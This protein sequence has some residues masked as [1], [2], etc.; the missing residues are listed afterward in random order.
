MR[1]TLS[2]TLSHLCPTTDP[3]FPPQHEAAALRLLLSARYFN[4]SQL[5]GQASLRLPHLAPTD[6]LSALVTA[7]HA[8]LEPIKGTF[9]ITFAAPIGRAQAAPLFEGWC[10][11]G[12]IEVT[13]TPGEGGFALRSFDA[14]G[15]MRGEEKKFE[16]TGVEGEMGCFL[17]LVRSGGEEDVGAG[18][19][20][21]V[22]RDLAFIEAGLGSGGK[23]VALGGVAEK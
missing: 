21:E 14:R 23:E 9:N 20:E 16:R 8:S 17:G 7:S 1:P 3:L 13:Q 15:K 6:T 5:T 4:A 19:P 12:W 11:K 18:K 10:E 2:A 22:L